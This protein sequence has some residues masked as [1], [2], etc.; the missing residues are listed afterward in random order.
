MTCL[1]S[2]LCITCTKSSHVNLF[3]MES[4]KRIR[5]PPPRT[6]GMFHYVTLHACQWGV[7]VMSNWAGFPLQVKSSG[8][9]KMCGTLQQKDNIDKLYRIW[10]LSRKYGGSGNSGGGVGRNTRSVWDGSGLQ[11]GCGRNVSF[12]LQLKFLYDNDSTAIFLFITRRASDF[13]LIC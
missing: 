7:Q 9:R 2:K 6:H 4:H 11:M 5:P 3:L 8:V 1:N 12:A 13:S 10:G